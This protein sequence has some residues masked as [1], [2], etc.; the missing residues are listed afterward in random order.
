MV[1]NFDK[2]LDD[3]K[4]FFRYL[5]RKED[6]EFIGYVYFNLS[7]DK[8]GIGIVVESK[9]QGNKYSKEG[10]IL[11]LD[12]AFNKFNIDKVY[13]SFEEERITSCKSFFDLGFVVE[14]K[15]ISKKFNEDIN[16]IDISLTKERYNDIKNIK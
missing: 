3:S 1:K 2:R 8:Y 9:Y 10:L 4:C 7:G 14:N 11:L 16:I 15:F 13:D 12:E 6:N 5:V